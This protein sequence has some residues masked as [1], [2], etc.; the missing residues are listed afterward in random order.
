[1]PIWTD[2]LDALRRIWT[3]RYSNAAQP[4]SP[5]TSII[6]ITSDTYTVPT[7]GQYYV[8]IGG[9]NATE[10]QD[11][12]TYFNA[13]NRRVVL[14]AEHGVTFSPTRQYSL[15]SEAALAEFEQRSRMLQ[16][17]REYEN[18]RDQQMVLARAQ[19]NLRVNPFHAINELFGAGLI[20][21]TSAMEIML[22]VPKAKAAP[23][24]WFV[25]KKA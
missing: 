21:S 25:R 8:S 3:E 20:D 14:G 22:G 16:A 2:A 19:E 7:S 23:K 17:Q 10:Y 1:M 18:L 24:V 5:N 9:I 12:T 15:S 13:F 4:E 6:G 11:P